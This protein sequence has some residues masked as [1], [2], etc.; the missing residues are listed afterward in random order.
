MAPPTGPRSA[1]LTPPLRPLVPQSDARAAAQPPCGSR[2]HVP[3]CAR[4]GFARMSAQSGTRWA[5]EPGPAEGL[6]YIRAACAFTNP[7][8]LGF[9][10]SDC[11][12]SVP[13]LYPRTGPSASFVDLVWALE[14]VSQSVG[15]AQIDS[16]RLVSIN[17]VRVLVRPVAGLGE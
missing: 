16:V 15:A 13:A 12:G 2:L 1:C 10:K 7:L 3:S 11:Q 14:P 4:A 5:L 8:Y 17:T 6:F 9:H